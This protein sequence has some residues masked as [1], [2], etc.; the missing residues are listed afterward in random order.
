MEE[1]LLGDI[2]EQ[3]FVSSP[4]Q[5]SLSHFSLSSDDYNVKRATVKQRCPDIKPRVTT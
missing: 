1:S 4:T 3:T 2:N 5:K